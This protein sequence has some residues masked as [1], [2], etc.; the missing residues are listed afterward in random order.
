MKSWL[1]LI[2]NAIRMGV[3]WMVPWVFVGFLIEYVHDAW[4][5]ALGR[6]VDIWPAALGLPT[7]LGG[8]TFAMLL[9]IAARRR[10]FAE[11]SLPGF[12]ALGA[13]G[14]VLVG[15][16]PAV[17]VMLG[18]ASLHGDAT[19]WDITVPM[20]GPLALLGGSTAAAT[21]LLARRAERLAGSE[22]AT[23]LGS[24]EPGARKSPPRDRL[25]PRV[26][27]TRSPW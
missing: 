22:S 14:V 7:L 3:T 5:N 19:M 1:R 13:L 12:T 8:I 11:L 10:R 6:M 26:G 9:G 27:G 18:L 21:L 17:M 23:A 25:K 15:L 20:M 24:T 4:P 2:P 16:A